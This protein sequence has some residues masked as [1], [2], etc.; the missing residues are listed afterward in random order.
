[1]TV[2]EI[3]PPLSFSPADQTPMHWETLLGNRQGTKVSFLTTVSYLFVKR[4]VPL[5]T[6]PLISKNGDTL[7]DHAL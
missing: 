7:S 5:E 1:L 2:T 6:I 4:S 3:E